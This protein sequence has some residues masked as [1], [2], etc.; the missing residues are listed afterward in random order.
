M[1]VRLLRGLII[2][3]DAIGINDFEALAVGAVTDLTVGVTLT[4]GCVW[5]ETAIWQR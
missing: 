1:N 2:G 4:G 3:Y 5:D